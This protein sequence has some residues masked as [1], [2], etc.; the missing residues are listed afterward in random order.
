M[1]EALLVLQRVSGTRLIFRA[2]SSLLYNVFSV[3]FFRPHFSLYNAIYNAEGYPKTASLV[4]CV[5][6]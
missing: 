4:R 2:L 6:D 5:R 3:F 1:T